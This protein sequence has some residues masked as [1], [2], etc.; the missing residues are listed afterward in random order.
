MGEKKC[1]HPACPCSA[2]AG[3]AFCSDECRSIRTEGHAC[4]CTHPGC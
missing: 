1:A 4:P 2:E 3:Q